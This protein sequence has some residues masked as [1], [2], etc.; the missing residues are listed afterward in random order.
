MAFLDT[1]TG[2]VYIPRD[3][4]TN[5]K[6]K[7]SPSNQL[8]GYHINK[9]EKG[10]LGHA[11]KIREEYEE[12]LDAVAQ[13]AKLME[14]MELADLLGAIEAYAAKYN[15]TLYD[16]NQMKDLNKRAFESGHRK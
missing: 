13:G 9:I 10:V 15:V 1:G 6:V 16:L 11:S 7:E 8:S 12:F 5:E 3:D 14:L 4:T 2:E